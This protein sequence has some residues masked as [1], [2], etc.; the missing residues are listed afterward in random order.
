MDTIDLSYS[1]IGNIL[2]VDRSSETRALERVD[3]NWAP[4][5]TPDET[6]PSPM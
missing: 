3:L 2:R 1:D 4:A 5:E 6:G